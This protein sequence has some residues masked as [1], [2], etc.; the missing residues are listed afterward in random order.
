LG[1]NSETAILLEK[2][3]S[4]YVGPLTIAKDAADYFSGSPQKIL[5]R[6]DTLF[7][8]SLAQLQK[9]ARSAHFPKAF[10]F[11]MD[12]IHLVDTLHAF[13]AQYQAKIIVKHLDH[14]A[15]AVDGMISTTKL[16][17]EQEIW[18]VNTAAQATVWWL[19]NPSKAFE[20]LT[21]SIHEIL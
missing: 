20:A 1:R 21:T 9:L 16:D 17:E 6:P 14:I 5:E 18:R 3:A 7:V 2:L 15:V 8:I 4:T 10:T 11:G 19:Q 12:L 13:T